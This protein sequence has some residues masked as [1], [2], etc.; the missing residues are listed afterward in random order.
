SASTGRGAAGIAAVKRAVWTRDGGPCA[1][2]AH[3]GRRCGATRVVEFHHVQPRG[4]CGAFTVANIQ[5][6]RRA[7]NGHEVDLFFG[8]GVRRTRGGRIAANVAALDGKS[9]TE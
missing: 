7:H 4:A 5:L 8:P 9:P 3:D 6:R 1:F 2:V